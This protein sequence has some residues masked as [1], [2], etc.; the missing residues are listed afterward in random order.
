VR[1]LTETE[2]A[3]IANALHVAAEVYERDAKETRAQIPHATY[4]PPLARLALQ[5]EDQAAMARRLADELDGADS[6]WVQS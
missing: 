4:T 3:A 1:R 6:V 2:H 5:F